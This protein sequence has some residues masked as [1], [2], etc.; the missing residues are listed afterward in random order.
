ME[1]MT[2]EDFMMKKVDIE[3]RMHQTRIDERKAIKA[4]TLQ[5]EDRLQDEQEKF[6]KQR[7]SIMEERDMKRVEIENEY[8]QRRR[9]LW[10]EDCELVDQWRRQLGDMYITPPTS[11][12]GQHNNVES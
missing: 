10:A 7:N 9:E 5:F 2:R 11:G 1:R 4:M 12:D 6:R 8:K 3:T